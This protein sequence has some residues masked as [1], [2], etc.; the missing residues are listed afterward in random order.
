RGAVGIEPSWKSARGAGRV[1]LPGARV[2]RRNPPGPRGIARRVP[3]RQCSESDTPV[4]PMGGRA[5][6]GARTPGRVGIALASKLS[7]R[8]YLKP[9]LT[10]SRRHWVMRFLVLLNQAAE[11][12]EVSALVGPNLRSI[13][14]CSAVP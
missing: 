1:G 8:K 5:S 7:I 2:H 14:D 11:N 10:L 13:R 9:G 12:S 6:R 3:P 4:R